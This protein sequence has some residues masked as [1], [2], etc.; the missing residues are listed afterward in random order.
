MK[1]ITLDYWLEDEPDVLF[2]FDLIMYGNPYYGFFYTIDC[3][4]EGW[5][6]IECN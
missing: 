4:C 5:E 6:E 1:Q 3:Y 2:W